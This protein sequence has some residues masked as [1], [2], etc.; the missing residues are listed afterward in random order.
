[1]KSLA[2]AWKQLCSLLSNFYFFFLS[3]YFYL[4]SLHSWISMERPQ[5]IQ[6]LHTNINILP[7]TAT[8]AYIPDSCK[9]IC[10]RTNKHLPRVILRAKSYFLH[11]FA[12]IIKNKINCNKHYKCWWK[13]KILVYI[14]KCIRLLLSILI[15]QLSQNSSFPKGNSSFFITFYSKPLNSRNGNFLKEPRMSKNFTFE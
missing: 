1:M 11:C 3:F 15:L 13:I 4:K 9:S 5:V 12:K 7:L 6:D 8:Q 10:E 14:F 2:S